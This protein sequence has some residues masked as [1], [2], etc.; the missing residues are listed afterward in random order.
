MALTFAKKSS[1][2]APSTVEPEVKKTAAPEAKQPSQAPSGV[3]AMSFMKKGT[4]AKEAMAAEE[5][6]AELARAD[7]DK[8]WRF[9]MK[10]GEDRKITFLDGELDADK[11]LDVNMYFEHTIQV[12]GR[13][14]NF[15]CTADVDPS[16]ECPIC[17]RG[18]NKHALVGAL[19]IIDHTPYTIAKGANAGKVIENQKKLFVAKKG[20]L[21]LLTKIAVKRGGLTGCTFDASRNGEMNTLAQIMATYGL[22]EE[23]VTHANYEHE[24]TYRTPEELIALGVGKAPSGPGYGNGKVNTSALKN[25]L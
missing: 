8:L 7:R 24:I 20:T 13:W 3:P 21:A 19:T 25:E 2:V 10:Q 14:E 18:D 22:D 6:K 11:M 9:M 23:G 15:V 4:A 16:Q 1:S 12:N 17:A 5:A